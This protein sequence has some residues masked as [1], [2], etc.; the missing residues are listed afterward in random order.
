MNKR[1]AINE[2]LLSLNELPL[3]ID[4]LVEDVQTAVIV[5]KELEIAR[6]KILSQ[7]WYFNKTT[8]ELTPN[9]DGYIIVPNNFFSVDPTDGASN[10]VVRD[11]KLF[12]KEDMTFIFTDTVTCDVVEDITFDDIP[13]TV[14]DYIVQT[15]SLRA[16]INIIGNSEDVNVRK[17]EIMQ[18]RLLAIKENARM[19]DGNVLNGTFVTSL[20]D[21]ESL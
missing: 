21:R 12:N 8:R 20:L 18:A 19:I 14:A 4:D 16:Y 5:D 17:E 1:D 6:K 10:I 13:F 3:D 7:G 9:V 2:I 15:A 11:W